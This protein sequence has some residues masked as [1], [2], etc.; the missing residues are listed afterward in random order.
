MGML[1]EGEELGSNLLHVAQVGQ[2]YPGGLG[3][4]KIGT[5]T[6]TLRSDREMAVLN[7]QTA[8]LAAGRLAPNRKPQLAPAG[9]LYRPHQQARVRQR[10]Q[11]VR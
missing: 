4:M 10:D 8:C 9:G 2:D 5:A 3:S 11:A 6:G 7:G 1:A